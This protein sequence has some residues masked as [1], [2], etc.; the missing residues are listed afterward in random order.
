MLKSASCSSLVLILSVA[1]GGCGSGVPGCTNRD[2]RK[3]VL[4]AAADAVFSMMSDEAEMDADAMRYHLPSPLGGDTGD[5]VF[6]GNSLTLVP[7]DESRGGTF[8][9]R[10]VRAESMDESGRGCAATFVMIGGNPEVPLR[11]KISPEGTIEGSME[12][13]RGTIELP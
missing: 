10:D 7:D 3:E 2:V 8:H 4:V 9:L 5:L 12:T 13:P 1:L 11:Y 6:E